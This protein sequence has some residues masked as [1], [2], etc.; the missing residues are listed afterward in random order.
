MKNNLEK[1]N[2]KEARIMEIKEMIRNFCDEYLNDEMESYALKLTENIGRKRKIDILR[3]KKEIWAA[4]IIYVIARINFLFD[5]DNDNHIIY[6]TICNYFNTVKSTTGN[7]ASQ[8]QDICK[9][10]IGTEG[11]CSQEIVDSLT[12]VQT[13]EGFIIPKKWFENRKI[14]IE[15]ATDEEEDEIRQFE[16]KQKQIELQKVKER[17]EKRAE[18]NREIARKKKEKEDKYQLSLF[19]D[20]DN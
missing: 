2:E 12:F 17:D 1:K 7:K 9:I 13:P 20:F 10:E 4:S 14:I 15:T 16:E 19:D 6:D 5:R 18:I 11:Y 8:I 3:G